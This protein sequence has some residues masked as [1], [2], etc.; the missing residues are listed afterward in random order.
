M[1]EQVPRTPELISKLKRKHLSTS[2]M[3]KTNIF[4]KYILFMKRKKNLHNFDEIIELFLSEKIYN[5]ESDLL[6]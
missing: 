4:L 2:R 6:T 5:E 3:K 1:L